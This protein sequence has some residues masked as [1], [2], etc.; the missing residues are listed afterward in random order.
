MDLEQD[1]K[2]DS[3]YTK[4]LM[5]CVPFV[6]GLF[7][8]LTFNLALY[9]S[10]RART[11][12]IEQHLD[13]A[14]KHFAGHGVDG[15]E[16][17]IFNNIVM[18]DAQYGSYNKLMPWQTLRAT[19]QPGL[20]LASEA[21]SSGLILERG[22]ILTSAYVAIDSVMITVQR[23]GESKRYPAS[24]V[25]VAADLDLALVN[26]THPEFWA[27]NDA[28]VDI[29]SAAQIMGLS[30]AVTLAGFPVGADLSI[31]KLESRV[32]RIEADGGVNFG[33]YGTF[34]RSV[35]TLYPAIGKDLS[36][37]P[38]FGSDNGKLEGF[39]GQNNAVIPVK[40]IFA[41]V[42]SYKQDKKWSGLGML[43]MI[44]R[45]MQPDA[46]RKYWDLP[47]D[48]IGVQIRS[49]CADSP[50][51]D[52]QVKK[53]DIL[54]EIDGEPIMA[55][56]A[57]IYNRSEDHKVALP[58]QVLLGE[59]NPGDTTTLTIFR[60]TPRGDNASS[61]DN[62]GNLG[63]QHSETFKV[64]VEMRQ[65]PAL[66]PRA[67]DEGH[68]QQPKYFILGGLVWTVFTEGLLAACK[69]LGVNLIPSS[70][71]AY[72]LHRWREHPDEEVV[73]LL[74]QLT[75]P[76]NKFYAFHG[77]QVL[78]YFN[79]KEVRNMSQ[80]VKMAGE[81]LSAGADLLQ[82]A[83]LPMN[84][85]DTAGGQDDPDI[86]LDVGLCRGADMEILNMHQIVAPFSEDLQKDYSA[87][88]LEEFARGGGFGQNLS[89]GMD[90]LKPP[91]T[92]AMTEKKTTP[93]VEHSVNRSDTV[94]STSNE[95][96]RLIHNIP[97]HN[98]V[99]IKL[100]SADQD[101]ISP[102]KTMPPGA[103]RC[104]AIIV[105]KDERL[106]LTNSHCVAN[107]K[108]LDVLREDAA[109]PV[110][111]RVVEIA[112][113]VDLAW[114][115][116]DE[117]KFWENPKIKT[118]VSMSAGPPNIAS[119]VR[120]VGYP[121]G[122]KSITITQGI[123]SRI[124]GQVY[125]NGLVPSARNTPDN[126]LIVQVDAAINPGNS[127]GPVFDTDGNLLGLA[128]AGLQGAQS[129]G[130]VI[131]NIHC[132]HFINSVAET[133]RWQAQLEAGA[134]FRTVENV[135]MRKFLHLK[136]DE[137]GV[138]VRSVSK[139]SPLWDAGV[140]KGDVLLSV[141]G[142]K[143]EG[144][145]TV[146]R[147]INGHQVSMPF[148]TL[149]TEKAHNETLTMDFVRPNGKDGNP[150]YIH[151][152]KAFHPIPPLVP[153]FFDAP[154]EVAGRE[155]FAAK[156]SYFMIWGL[157]FG[158]FSNPVFQQAMER[159]IT[160][161]W[162]LQKKA[163]HNW[164]EDENDEVVVLLQGLN[165]PCNMYYDLSVMRGLEYF[166]GKPV[167]NLKEFMQRAIAAE[168]SG[169][170]YMRFTWLP[171]A[172][173]DTAGSTTDP[174]IVLHRDMC[175]GV[176]ASLMQNYNIESRFSSDLRETAA[177]TMQEL[178]QQGGAQQGGAQQGFLKIVRNQ[179]GN[180]F[181]VVNGSTF[182][183]LHEAAAEKKA[184]QTEDE[185]HDEGES[186]GLESSAAPGAAS[187]G[188]NSSGDGGTAQVVP[189]AGSLIEVAGSERS[190]QVNLRHRLDSRAIGRF[191]LTAG[192][193]AQATE[194]VDM[195]TLEMPVDMPTLEM[196]VQLYDAVRQDPVDIVL[197]SSDASLSFSGSSSP[198]HEM[199]PTD[200]D[201]LSSDVLRAQGFSRRDRRRPVGPSK[202]DM[203]LH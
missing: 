65:L 85:E 174:D 198:P 95:A 123:V 142:I 141:A 59:K 182:Q 147:D 200:L 132:K 63:Y 166:N 172:D 42:A 108:S 32:A 40:T 186:K 30:T 137:T 127:G 34:P 107:A 153:R 70:T 192:A 165:H 88:K 195:P 46:L 101:F 10:L 105:D 13:F 164:L 109:D 14:K 157:V 119:G 68:L 97:W 134:L 121:T 154:K 64:T 49:V 135:G 177:A 161:P 124:D 18:I 29:A 43:G 11:S 61:N 158:V 62:S 139:M 79:G 48:G 67:A 56:G 102:W 55:N 160:V 54:R 44:V 185:Q 26:V 50:L 35:L 133:G 189:R 179:S 131:P 114:I 136:D 146:L 116:T 71:S 171:M 152:E 21:T 15:A 92:R 3:P 167:K 39:I 144:A 16:V 143:V 191:T 23:Q 125:P 118:T 106:I 96:Q 98:V 156:P 99:Q 155:H 87:A 8:C 76:C 196:P 36:V 128:F 9:L 38:V 73:V 151:V 41:F 81:E 159:K 94:D 145:G 202:H 84:D 150:E 148:D 60:S 190:P 140:R 113:D 91:P 57:I 47:N 4:P 5:V 193:Q 194:P 129:T 24:I 80:F 6:A 2:Q 74:S 181:L 117:A 180:E 115:T 187:T 28:V 33:R 122:G 183:K 175:A 169:E 19:L 100:V 31:S 178:A 111:A 12:S 75:H 184:K 17:N 104:S 20:E 83:F 170:E 163:L 120:V 112:H 77:A 199:P 168:A 72:A 22:L 203:R 82:F 7:I 27:V 138:Q 176:D 201:G 58:F 45:P 89:K 173:E 1:K 162:T 51:H 52:Q 69:A 53:G 86:V 78:K 188:R 197:G 90:K 126:L 93:A 149:V 103:S 37:G 66:V 130:Y 110:P 25:T